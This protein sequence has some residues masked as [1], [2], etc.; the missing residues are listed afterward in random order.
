MYCSSLKL[1]IHPWIYLSIHTFIFLSYHI[2]SIHHIYII[3]L[4]LS[5][6]LLTRFPIISFSSYL[7]ILLFLTIN[8][9]TN[10]L[11]SIFMS[12]YL[13]I[14]AVCIVFLLI[15]RQLTLDYLS[16]YKLVIWLDSYIHFMLLLKLLNLVMLKMKGKND[17]IYMSLS[18]CYSRSSIPYLSIYLNIYLSKYLSIYLSPIYFIV[19]FPI[20]IILLFYHWFL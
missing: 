10:P 5:I 13:S 4:Y 18:V 16:I 6:H 19:N 14:G 12:I 9:P 17:I 8:T 11:V 2:I 3:L 7:I 15:Q 20:H 1:F